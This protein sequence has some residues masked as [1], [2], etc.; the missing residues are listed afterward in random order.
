M[1]SE[2]HQASGLVFR[3]RDL[4]MKQ[5]T[6]LMNVIRG[7]LAEYGW[8][9]PKGPSWVRMLADL[10]EDE[11]GESLPD[12][13][14]AMLRVMHEMLTFLDARVDELDKEIGRQAR[15]DEVC[16]RLMTIPGI[17]PITVTAIAAL[18]PVA[19]TFRRGRDFAAWLGLT[20][21]QHSTGG[22]TKLERI[23]KMSDRTSRRLSAS[24]SI[25]R[26]LNGGCGSVARTSRWSIVATLMSR[27]ITS[28]EAV[29]SLAGAITASH[30]GRLPPS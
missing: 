22:K 5:R 9:A 12:G 23:T 21:L 7:H 6:Q 19:E 13:A 17:G 14:R 28:A 10:L 2:E 29:G 25:G 3:T 27:L 11:M 20:P 1:K 30:S 8:V 15:E 18:A 24:L 4:L 16:R 26:I